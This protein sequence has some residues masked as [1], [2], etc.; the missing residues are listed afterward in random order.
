VRYRELRLVPSFMLPI[1]TK[2]SPFSGLANEAF[3]ANCV[4]LSSLYPSLSFST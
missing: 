4:S 3:L 2:A 1:L